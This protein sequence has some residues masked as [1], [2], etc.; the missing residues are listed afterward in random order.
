MTHT[1]STWVLPIGLHATWLFYF[2][3]PL[4]I[5][6]P[7]CFRLLQ[8]SHLPPSY[9]EPSSKYLLDRL[10]S[11]PSQLS[12]LCFARS[13]PNTE[14]PQSWLQMTS[15]PRYATW[16]SPQRIQ[17][18]SVWLVRCYVQRVYPIRLRRFDLFS[19]RPMHSGD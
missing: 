9:E 11:V 18:V 7:F 12:G 1:R 16:T 10:K 3:R 4:T 2:P 17:I 13:T 15:T 19:C 8:D 6:T 14:T 5:E